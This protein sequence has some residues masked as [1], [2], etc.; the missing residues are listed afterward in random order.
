M[1]VFT[2]GVHPKR[3]LK[4]QIVLEY[5]YRQKGSIWL[6][7]WMENVVEGH[8]EMETKGHPKGMGHDPVRDE[9]I[10]AEMNRVVSEYGNNPSFTMFCIGNE[11]GNADFDV[12]KKWIADL[13]LKDSRRLYSVSTARKITSSDDFI[14][15]HYIQGVGR[16]RG[17]NGATTDWDFEE[18][19]S[20]MDIPVI[21]HEIG[22]WPVYPQWSEIEKYNGVLKA[23]NIEGS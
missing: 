11:L 12:A 18:F 15:T 9:F 21:A 23:R 1:L 4:L 13:K 3:L 14:A 19:Y 2:H 22:Q 10:I 17:L 7:W 6:D 5:I 16:T 20:K 8:P